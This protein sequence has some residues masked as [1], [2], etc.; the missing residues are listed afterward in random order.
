METPI[1]FACQTRSYQAAIQLLRNIKI[2]INVIE[3]ELIKSGYCPYVWDF[4]S[5]EKAAICDC[6]IDKNFVP[7]KI[8]FSKFYLR[9]LNLFLFDPCQKFIDNFRY[10]IGIQGIRTD[11]DTANCIARNEFAAAY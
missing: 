9:I 10:N 5:K 11:F 7:G 3:R 2:R 6:R 8:K 1:F 4:L